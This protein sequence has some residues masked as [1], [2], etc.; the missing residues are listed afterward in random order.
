MKFFSI[1]MNMNEW[2]VFNKLTNDIMQ[3]HLRYM[4]R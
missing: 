3:E 2:R 1:A 4:V